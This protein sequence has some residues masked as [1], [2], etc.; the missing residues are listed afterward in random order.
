MAS[1]SPAGPKVLVALG[2][3]PEAV[4]LA[5]V[6]HAARDHD[7]WT[8]RVCSTGQHRDLLPPILRA[9]QVQPDLELDVMRPGQPLSKLLA[10]L[11]VALDDTLAAEQPQWVVAQGDTT[12]VLAAAL[13][14]AHRRIPFAHVEAGLRTH[15]L[16]APFPEEANRT[17]AA[18]VTTL[19]LAP[20]RRACANLR[21]E[22][23]GEAA[24]T[25]TGNTV[26]DALRSMLARL[27]ADGRAPATAPPTLAALPADAPLVLVTG[28]RRESFDGGLRT[29]CEA[30]AALAGAHPDAWFVYPVH[31]NPQV[32]ATVDELLRDR[33]SVR[34]TPPVDYATMAWLMRRA[35]F[36][37]TDS[38]GLQE[39]APELRLPV[40]VTRVAT[41]RPEA[42]EEG[43]AVVVG[44]DR[45]AIVE[46]ADRWLRDEVAYEAAR[47]KRNPF[48]DGRA[49]LRCVA[50]LRQR[51]GLPG[52]DVEAWPG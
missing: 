45:D 48:G 36:C 1:T 4:K 35:K 39:E 5:P 28:H 26:V 46:T 24:I 51:L 15:D 41:E 19:H 22:G 38:G 25:L 14:A 21:A 17:L 23:I 29:V 44:Y 20:S 2:T 42:V 50:A 49:G 6:I 47:P 30:L 27:P 7:D 13:A 32:R 8:V 33:A 34:L 16:A 43:G 9:V 18:D 52:P 40:M 31:F 3:R 37:V 12:T 11:L 10:G